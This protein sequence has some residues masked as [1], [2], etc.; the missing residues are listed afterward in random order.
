[1][2]PCLFIQKQTLFPKCL[3]HNSEQTFCG[4][5]VT[6]CIFD[7]CNNFQSYI[8]SRQTIVQ[9]RTYGAYMKSFPAL[10]AHSWVP[11]CH[12]LCMPWKCLQLLELHLFQLLNCH[13]LPKFSSNCFCAN[14]NLSLFMFATVRPVVVWSGIFPIILR[15][16]SMT[17]PTFSKLTLRSNKE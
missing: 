17:R 1:M 16:V 9:C 4:C 12:A 13:V 5:S 7:I 2:L 6:H 11:H 10:Q 15:T 8:I 3:Q 14:N